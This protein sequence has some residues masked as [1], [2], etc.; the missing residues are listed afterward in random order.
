M[1]SIS[2]FLFSKNKVNKAK[3]Q[4]LQQKQII[5]QVLDVGKAGI[6]LVKTGN[7]ESNLGAG[8][9]IRYIKQQI[10]EKELEL[11]ELQIE[12]DEVV[13]LI[14]S[15]QEQRDAID[16][17]QAAIDE[18]I[19]AIDLDIN[20]KGAEIAQN[21]EA[22]SNTDKLESLRKQAKFTSQAVCLVKESAPKYA[23]NKGENHE[24]LKERAK[25]LQIRIGKLEFE[26]NVVES[27]VVQAIDYSNFDKE[28]E[29]K[30]DSLLL[31]IR[32]RLDSFDK[33]LNENE[34]IM[35]V[36]YLFSD[37]FPIMTDIYKNPYQNKILWS[38]I[39]SK[40]S[41]N[42]NRTY[43]SSSG[44]S[45]FF[46]VLEGQLKGFEKSSDEYNDMSAEYSS[47]E[48]EIQNSAAKDLSLFERLSKLND[49]LEA[50]YNEMLAGKKSLETSFSQKINLDQKVKIEELNSELLAA[51]N[52]LLEIN[53]KFELKSKFEGVI[54]TTVGIIDKVD[55]KSANEFRG[56]AGKFIEDSSQENMDLLFEFVGRLSIS[57]QKNIDNLQGG[58]E[59][60][61][62]RNAQLQLQRGDLLAKKS[63]NETLKSEQQLGYQ[64]TSNYINQ[65]SESLEGIQEKIRAISEKIEQ[66]KSQDSGDEVH[67]E[68]DSLRHES[69]LMLSEPQDFI[70]N[71]EEAFVPV[72]KTIATNRSNAKQKRAS[73]STISSFGR[74]SIINDANQILSASKAKKALKNSEFARVMKHSIAKDYNFR[75]TNLFARKFLDLQQP[76]IQK[77]IELQTQ[78][79]SSEKRRAEL[80]RSKVELAKKREENESK[81]KAAMEKLAKIS[82]RLSKCGNELIELNKEKSKMDQMYGSKDTKKVAGKKDQEN[83]LDILNSSFSTNNSDNSSNRY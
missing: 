59:A 18:E 36:N 43:Q 10:K 53:S 40:C 6:E 80:E 12:S 71:D 82:E 31:E 70:E 7:G 17:S 3:A 56:I 62:R 52:S 20:S 69:A 77:D 83:D 37:S 32:N 65:F 24:V 66:L 50:G 81:M 63:E 8:G 75:D 54:S 60:L 13:G 55:T 26:L 25:E 16:Q 44:R 68:E 11:A 21:N 23:E 35:M 49:K 42:V 67:A 30:I 28:V 14:R 61:V 76:L 46:N 2:N 5:G 33:S 34:T 22:I 74:E 1:K 4:E 45:D 41:V 15:I 58:T 9:Y 57:N 29:Q 64:S 73:N 39:K 19:A 27:R 48:S 78:K 79:D 38:D 47:I 72:V 51:R